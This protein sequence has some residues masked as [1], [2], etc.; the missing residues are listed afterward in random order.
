MFRFVIH[1]SCWS[2]LNANSPHPATLNYQEVFKELETCVRQHRLRVELHAFYAQFAVAQTHDYPVAGFGGNFECARQ[3]FS[4]DDKRMIA[5]GNERL[6]QTAEYCFAVMLNFAGLSVHYFFGTDHAASKRSADGLV[7]EA[8]AENRNFPCEA[9][10]ERDANPSFLGG[11]R[12]GGDY[13]AL[14]M[15][16]LNFVERYLVISTDFDI[17]A[18]LAEILRQIKCKG[19]VVVDEQ[20]HLYSAADLKFITFDFPARRCAQFA[21]RP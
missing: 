17:L 21:K 16:L 7:A 18:H 10:N 2:W 12:T 8:N 15:E 3:R 9:L 14:G 19:I 11:A 20:N 4:I 6:R 1:G 13:D 5:C